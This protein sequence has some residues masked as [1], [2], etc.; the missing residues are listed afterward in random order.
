MTESLNNTTKERDEVKAKLESATDNL[1]IARVN[2]KEKTEESEK[3][4]DQVKVL[5][6]DLSNTTKD[7]DETKLK[8]ENTQKE[9][10][11]LQHH[12]GVSKDTQ[13]ARLCEA[14]KQKE[15]YRKMLETLQS[16]MTNLQK[17]AIKCGELMNRLRES[18]ECRR[19]LHNKVVELRGNIRV[20]VRTRPFLG[21]ES[22]AD[23]APIR[24]RS[25]CCCVSF[26]RRKQANHA[27]SLK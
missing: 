10:A 20:F 9:L 6:S 23:G 2:V 3:L 7:R 14:E 25:C 21:E 22:A 19:K 5:T 26:V 18:E 15:E 11:T 27:M 8:F 1:E 17:D 4:Q 24:V 16:Q 12:Y 13:L